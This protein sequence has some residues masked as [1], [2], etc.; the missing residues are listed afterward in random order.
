[1]PSPIDPN[2]AFNGFVDYSTFF[3]EPSIIWIAVG[4]II[5][6]GSVISVI[7]QIISI[8]KRKSSFG[9]NVISIFVTSV[10]QFILLTNVL[11]FHIEDFRG[12]LQFPFIQV[13]PRFLT[14][15]ITF[16]L[17]IFFLAIPFLT[18]IFF[19]KNHPKSQTPI[20]RKQ[21]NI[22]TTVLTVAVPFSSFIFLISYFILGTQNGFE[23]KIVLY[24][25]GI[26]GSISTIIGFAQYIPQMITTC[27]IEGPGSLSL[28]LLFIQ[29]P[30]GTANALFMAI[31]QG[32]HWTTWISILSASIQQFILIGIILYYK[33]KKSRKVADNSGKD[34]QIYPSYTTKEKGKET[35][36]DSN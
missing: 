13:I 28:I 8:L 21:S 27:S 12:F 11:C 23:S 9:L 19:D 36:F 4:S 18:M 26:C 33:C 2:I 5:F 7:P 24:F 1:M 6:I 14:F 35:N 31:A 3:E 34:S 20:D 32:D 16:G 30:G 15:S 10:S 25:G 17:W 29:A 22:M